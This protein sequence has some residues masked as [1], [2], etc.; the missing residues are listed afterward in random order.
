MPVYLQFLLI[1]QI[2]GDKIATNWTKLM[3][4]SP[5][6]HRKSNRLLQWEIGQPL[7]LLSSWPAFSLLHHN[8]VWYCA[9]LEGLNPK[10]IQWVSHSWWRY[11]YLKWSGGNKVQNTIP[12]IRCWYKWK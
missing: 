3:V 9:W 6:L 7:G 1:K 11:R 12:R 5:F 8:L 2:F 10:N 4:N